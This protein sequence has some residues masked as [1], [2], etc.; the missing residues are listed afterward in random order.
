VA[1]QPALFAALAGAV[2][3]MA[4]GCRSNSS[5]NLE[6]GYSSQCKTQLQFYAPPGAQ[7]TVQGCYTRSHDIPVPG[8]YGDRLERSPEQLSVFNLGPGRYEFK[9]TTA[10]GLP[11]VSVYGELNIEHANSHEARV[12]QR[13]AFV[14][15][16]L[17]SEYYQNVEVVGDEIF[18]YR[19]ETYRTAIDEYDLVRL[20]QG[21]VIE[22][23]F[24]VADLEKAEYILDRTT[25][26]IAV[27]ER[28]IEYADA[29]F[30]QAYFDFRIGVS[31]PSANFWGTDREFID[32][33]RKRQQLEQRLTSLE[34]RAQRTKALLDGDHVLARR[35][36]L[37]LAT[38]EIVEP[39]RDVVSA[40]E[41][42][43]EVLVVMRVGGRHMD[44]GNP[45]GELASYEP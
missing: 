11:G 39:H 10:P 5:A 22:K 7:V 18:P 37:V 1:R 30:R 6:R 26:E 38:E 14:P 29:R 20:K 17:P 28:E 36:M 21:D 32:W 35:G 19:G 9:Y 3:L 23:V 12:F 15:I 4:A 25:E 16:S 33:E 34:E 42:L 40:S 8:A 45:R 41:E 27:A 44:W 2:I 43:G 13:R 31:D 24:F